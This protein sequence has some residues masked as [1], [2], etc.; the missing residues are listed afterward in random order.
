[1]AIK[2]VLRE[3]GWMKNGMIRSMTM[4]HIHE[5]KEDCKLDILFTL[6]GMDRTNRLNTLQ[7][8]CESVLNE[9]LPEWKTSSFGI[10]HF[11]IETEEQAIQFNKLH[12]Q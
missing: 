2:K 4:T 10:V 9:K 11:D 12:V 1:M 3:H 5:T 6:S 7:L 8:H